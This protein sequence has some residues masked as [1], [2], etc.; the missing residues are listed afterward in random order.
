MT[1]AIAHD[2]ECKFLGFPFPLLNYSHQIPTKNSTIINLSN[3]GQD[4]TLEVL[5]RSMPFN[6]TNKNIE[7]FK[8]RIF[9]FAYDTKNTLLAFPSHSLN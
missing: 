1:L 6:D 9:A 3:T 4:D 5:I 2:T 7:L 8:Y